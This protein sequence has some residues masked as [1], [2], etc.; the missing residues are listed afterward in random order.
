LIAGHCGVETKLR[1]PI[2]S[3]SL[4]IIRPDTIDTN[5]SSGGIDTVDGPLGKTTVVAVH[6]KVNG[7]PNTIKVEKGKTDIA[8]FVYGQL[9]N[10]IRGTSFVR[11]MLNLINTLNSATD[12][13]DAILKRYIS[14]LG[15]W[16]TRRSVEPIKRAA[17]DQDPG[18]DIFLGNLS[19]EEMQENLLTFY[20][21]DPRVPFWEYIEFLDHRVWSYSRSSDLWY[22]RN[23]TQ[24]SAE[25]LDAIIG[26][27]YAALQRCVKRGVENFWYT[28]LVKIN[29][30]EN[31]EVPRLNFGVEKTGIEDIQPE[32]FLTKVVEL[33]YLSE[34]QVMDLVKQMGFRLLEIAEAEDEEE[35]PEEEEPTEV[36]PDEEPATEEPEEPTENVN[37][38]KKQV[39]SR[40]LERL[41][42]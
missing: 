30:G 27:H 20:S 25:V 39:Y 12:A 5:K 40:L 3:S 28:P 24:A 37:K 31:A 7:K 16:K 26:R 23:A 1:K 9:G 19:V 32:P 15:V 29:L 11:G 13:V 33:G 34:K 17:Q 22:M 36:E 14:P 35:L 8:W 42:E 6:Q 38:T 21:I 18:E 41:D 2:E 4:K 10:D